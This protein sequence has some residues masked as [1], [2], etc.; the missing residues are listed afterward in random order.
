MPNTDTAAVSH[1]KDS[2]KFLSLDFIYHK[3]PLG[4][5]REKVY[6]QDD[7]DGSLQ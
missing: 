5:F 7:N 4:I 6:T 1:N 3:D 2:I